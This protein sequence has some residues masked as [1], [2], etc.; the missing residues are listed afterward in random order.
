M[1]TQQAASIQITN[2]TG[3]NAT[4][5]LFHKNSTNGKQS[6]R[7]EASSGATVGLLE[8]FFK[9]GLGS[10]TVQDWWSVMVQVQDGPSAGMYYNEGS[11]GGWK[12]CQLQSADAGQ[13][14]TFTL[15]TTSFDINLP[16]GAC[17]DTV[18]K[19]APY[20]PVSHVFVVMLENRSFDNMFAGSEVAKKLGSQI[21]VAS[22]SNSNSYNG[23]TYN[24]SSPMVDPMT[25]G[26][27]LTAD[28]GHEF[29]DVF[30]QLCGQQATWPE[31]GGPYPPV[32]TTI[33]M[34]GFVANYATSTTEQTKPPTAPPA[35]SHWKDVMACGDTNTGPG[36]QPDGFMWLASHGVICDHW[37]SSMPG[38]TWPNRFFVHG[39]SSAGFDDSPTTSQIKRFEVGP[40]LKYPNGSIFDALGQHGI[41]YRIYHDTTGPT[42]AF[43]LFN[44]NPSQGSRWGAIPQ[45]TSIYG[46]PLMEVQSLKQFADDLQGPYPYPYT[47]IE[48]HYGQIVDNTYVGGSSQHPMDGLWGGDQLLTAVY[49]GIAQSKYFPSSLLIVIYDEHGGLYDSVPPPAA[50]PPGDNYPPANNTH[51]FRFDRYGPRVP[52]VIVSPLLQESRNCGPHDI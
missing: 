29:L 35:Q 18:V 47:F 40:G 48:P 30:E 1:A 3:G 4:I 46:V 38:P 37:F 24:V 36:G 14:L 12:E 5:I 20:A 6:A 39:A 11:S 15:S 49:Q 26:N 19:R 43:S 32:N 16:S 17:S 25:S 13:T 45:V 23:Q 41:P 2:N 51:G 22:P 9:T 21:T 42:L 28:P 44:Q 52:G 8:V 27:S 50:V 7:F 10:F 31:G 33:D 34:S